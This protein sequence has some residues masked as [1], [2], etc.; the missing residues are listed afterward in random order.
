MISVRYDDGIFAAQTRGGISSYFTHLIEVFDENPLLGIEVKNVPAFTKSIALLESAKSSR[1]SIKMLDRRRIINLA[2]Y[3]SRSMSKPADIIHSTFYFNRNLIPGSVRAITIHD[4]T[5]ELYPEWFPEGNP[6]RF[7]ARH[8]EQADAIFC[9][10]ETTRADLIRL[11]PSIKAPIF[12]TP[13]AV[14]LPYLKAQDTEREL[15]S[16]TR[17]GAPYILYVGER[18]FYKGFAVLAG[19]MGRLRAHTQLQLVLVGGGALTG[20]E[21][22]ML[23]KAGLHDRYSHSTPSD[24]DLERLYSNAVAFVFPSI[25]EG[26]GLPVL[27]AMASGCPVIISDAPALIEVAGGAARVF[28]RGDAQE[29]AKA[30][31]QVLSLAPTERGIEIANGLNRA[32]SSTWEQTSRLTSEAYIALLGL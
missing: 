4:M 28:P 5:P 10:S 21:K 19:A 32:R 7:K 24:V 17:G 20:R 1:I 3:F 18:S 15:S 12:V 30:I 2:N 8:L 13:L 14:G 11:R 31:E 6:H 23:E 27:E 9:V 16:S 25:Y 29:L 22:A 26:F